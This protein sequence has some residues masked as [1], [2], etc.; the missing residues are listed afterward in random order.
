M[1]KNK[2]VLQLLIILESRHDAGLY[3]AKEPIEFL[4]QKGTRHSCTAAHQN[5]NYAGA[6]E[7]PSNRGQRSRRGGKSVGGR[8][9]ALKGGGA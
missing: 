1:R 6:F 5:V 4:Q 8:H 7:E 2:F 9:R 3:A